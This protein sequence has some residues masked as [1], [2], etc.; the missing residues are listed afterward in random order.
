MNKYLYS[1]LATVI[2]VSSFHVRPMEAPCGKEVSEEDTPAMRL[3]QQLV[4]ET[5]LSQQDRD[6]LYAAFVGDVN[7]VTTALQNGARLGARSGGQEGFNALHLAARQGHDQLVQLLLDRGAYI[8]ADVDT[9][10]VLPLLGHTPLYLARLERQWSVIRV[11]L[12]N[13]ASFGNYPVYA[14]WMS[15]AFESQPLV[16][17]ALLGQRFEINQILSDGNVDLAQLHEALLY[18]A[19]HHRKGYHEV[20]SRADI[21]RFLFGRIIAQDKNASFEKMLQWL[22]KLIVYY[23]RDKERVGELAAMYTLIENLIRGTEQPA[24]AL[25]SLQPIPD[26]SGRLA[27]VVMIGGSL[28]AYPMYQ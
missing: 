23:G 18:A 12:R 26:A 20:H 1:I 27:G 25:S 4:G 9:R 11:L 22:I 28:M 17:A 19:V 21:V 8:N 14:T 5:G 7:G 16:G 2:M 13:G 10:P 3:K 6:L 15:E 24:D